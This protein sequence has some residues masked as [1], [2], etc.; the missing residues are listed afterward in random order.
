MSTLKDVAR[1]AGLSVSTV[2]RYL[3]GTIKIK[4]ETEHRIDEAILKTDYS[5]NL[6][7][8]SM[9]TKFTKNI[10][11]VFPSMMNLIF[12]EIA[13]AINKV[14]EKNEYVLTTYTTNDDLEKEKTV[15]AKMRE[16]RVAGA[17]FVTEPIGNKDMSHIRTLEKAGIKTVMVDYFFNPSEFN[18]IST[19][20]NT[21]IKDIMH[22]LISEGYKKIGLIV[23][24][25]GQDKSEVY[26]ESYKKGL[27]EVNIEFDENLIEFM[28]FDVEATKNA[29]SKLIEKGVDAIFTITDRSAVIAKEVIEKTKLSIPNDIALVGTGNSEFSRLLKMTSLDTKHYRL[30]EEAAKMLL[31]RIEGKKVSKFLMIKPNIALRDTTKK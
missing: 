23:G 3:N 6:H 19:D 30:G 11:L 15:A 28:Y 27:E 20:Y 10:S 12:G 7:A 18:S 29:T 17:I 21:G 16:H 25:P 22:L 24:W 31:S 5:K 14:L 9:R 8:V 13:E 4:A 2:S 1:E 26:I